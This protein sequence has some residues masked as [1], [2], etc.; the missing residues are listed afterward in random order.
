[1]NAVSRLDWSAHIPPEAVG[2]AIV[3]L[4]TPEADAHLGRDFSLR[5]VEGRQVAGLSVEGATA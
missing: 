4:C 3:W 2:R 1:M 5:T